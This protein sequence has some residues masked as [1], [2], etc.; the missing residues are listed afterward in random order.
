MG[1]AFLE[2]EY[3]KFLEGEY[4]KFLEG[5][6]DQFRHLWFHYFCYSNEIVCNIWSVSS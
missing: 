4:D 5:E 1:V 6:Y 3:D 2:A